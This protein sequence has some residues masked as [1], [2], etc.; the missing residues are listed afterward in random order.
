MPSNTFNDAKESFGDFC[1]LIRKL[2]DP[3]SGCPWDLKQSHQTLAK[4][5]IEEAYEAATVMKE[6]DPAKM[7][8]ELGDVLLQVVLNAQIATDEKTFDID[9]VVQSIHN[10]MY[11]RHPHVFGTEAER[12]AREIPHIMK[13]WEEIKHSERA[14]NE[15]SSY[16]EQEGVYK[17]FPA[18]SQA[19]KIGKAARKVNFDWT[20]RDQVF[21]VLIGE[22][23]ELKVEWL[24][25]DKKLS[26]ELYSEL[27]DVYF[28]LAQ[29]CRHLDLEPEMVAMDG[30]HKFLKRFEWMEA[31]AKSR[32]QKISDL[33]AGTIEDL[34][35]RAKENLS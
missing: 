14:P 26:P 16:M 20:K 33:D 9:D 27:G 17:V 28:S 19:S 11:R 23:Q 32:G 8:D 21:D 3:V 4:Y 13:R 15:T 10:K 22:I 2:R 34:W 29:L 24:K 18:T 25:S 5:M 1:E 7:C 12:E 6:N 30:N 35:K 31:K